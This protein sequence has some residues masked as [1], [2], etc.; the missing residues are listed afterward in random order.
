[1]PSRADTGGDAGGFTALFVRR[2]VLA[3]VLNGMIVIAGLGALLGIEIR[4][5][6]DV[7]RPVITVTTTFTGAAPETMDREITAVI[8]GAMGRVSGVESISSRSSQGRSRVTV[9]FSGRTDIN[10]AAA[11]ARDSIGRVANALPDDADEPRIVKADANADPVMRIGVTTTGMSIESLT[12]L[13]ENQVVDRLIAVP[14]VADVQVFGGR[15]QIFRIDVDQLAL[16]S[17]GLS[18]AD[19]RD[20]LADMAFDRPAG[21]L[22]AANQSLVVRTTA[23]LDT[24]EAFGALMIDPGTRLSDVAAVTLGPDIG[25]SILRSNGE[26]GLGLGII[27]Q[28]QGNALAI[29]SGV[30]AAVDALAGELPEGV[31][32]FVTGDDAVF[33]DGAL[34]EVVRT[35]LLSVLIVV[36]IIYLFLRDW[37]ATLIPAMSI[38]VA[39]IG[40]LAL[41]Y[42]AGFSLNI[43]TLLALVLA[44]GLVVDDAIVVLENIVRRRAQG[45]GP[46]AAAVLGTRQVFFA[47]IATTATLAAVF[48]PL[49]F[50]P[51]QAG[52]LFREFGITLGLAVALSA[53]VALSLCP[54]LASRMLERMHTG[55]QQGPLARLGGRLEAGYHRLLRA[56][57]D[58]PLVI[59]TLLLCFGVVAWSLFAG[60]PREITPPEDRGSVFVRVA[61]PQGASIDY[62]ASKLAEL[63]DRTGFLRDSGEVVGLFSSAGAFGQTNSG[64]A[65][66]TLAPWDA[67]SRGQAEIVADI[68]RAAGQV[69]GIRAFAGTSNSLGIR[70]AGQ[71]LQFAIVGSSYPALADVGEQLVDALERE[72]GFGQLRLSY[73]TT[74]PQLFIEVDRDRASDLGIDI[75]GLGETL[76]AVL[77][78]RSVGSVFVDDRS[79][80]VKLTSST[81]PVRG[82]A[83]LENLFLATRSGEMVPMSS[84]VT[85]E[86][87]PIAP[88][89][90]RESQMRAVTVSASLAGD[91]TIAAGLDRAMALAGPM[92][93]PGMRIVPLAEAATLH[94]TAGNLAITFGFAI[95]VV[96]LVLAAQF[97]SFVSALII[98]ATV[99]FG[100]GCGVLAMVLTGVS[101]NVY[102]QIG[103]VLLVGIIAKNGILVVEFADQLR[104]HGAPV[105]EAI[106][107]ACRI[108]LRPVM[109]TMAATILGAMPLLVSPGA[110][111]EAR[112]ALGWVMVGGLGLAALLTLFVTPVAYLVLAGFS[113]PRAEETAR[114]D[115]ELAEVGQPAPLLLPGPRR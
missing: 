67:R 74:Q 65:I 56:A 109:M 106:E 27:R 33:I 2:P 107:E 5:L 43:L 25:N 87:R 22:A 90:A 72:P 68:E 49:S 36:G 13:V 82:P 18:L 92:L 61:A 85:L 44:T 46:R 42:L 3:L 88:E 41:I 11:D 95:L 6:P 96:A 70:G 19:V 114:L 100:L 83:D 12:N 91:A 32:I 1:M 51:G 76:Q 16:A 31:R 29:S 112:A 10:V 21:S 93:G 81:N 97:E 55:P 73:E 104:D 84:V 103:L 7:D 80:D 40:T 69:V 17:R 23:T 98:M 101:L 105:R 79:Y 38:P 86:E 37:R 58:A 50:L 35:L 26:S 53:L 113:R 20:A 8:E 15:E 75:D 110:G 30:R 48:V 99:P 4:E 24:P 14:G 34:H 78:G 89:L 47:V 57:L 28:A 77:D 54:M 45:M 52:G 94:E 102:S 60:L 66:F 63:E 108:R 59:A 64:F 39:L 71:G 9:E 115:R 62:V 111:A